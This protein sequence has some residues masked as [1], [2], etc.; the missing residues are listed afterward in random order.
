M[1]T[2][3]QIDRYSRQ[4]ILPEVGGRGQQR[5]SQS[6]LALA[7]DPAALEAILPYLA[8]AGVGCIHLPLVGQPLARM[9]A[10]I[11]K[12]NPEVRLEPWQDSSPP[13]D[14]T[15]FVLSRESE[16]PSL[17]ALDHSGVRP[18]MLIR[19]IAPRAI[20]TLASR[21][22]CLAC[23]DPALLAPACQ[24]PGSIELPA[25]AIAIAGGG[26]ILLQLL[27]LAAPA[28]RLLRCS[29]YELNPCTLAAGTCCQRCA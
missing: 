26:E 27:A 29:G 15:A 3:A 16:L 10:A 17:A 1:L 13:A 7:G 18:L 23:A 9:C 25:E 21:P 19:L 12:R 28:A 14:L 6:R 11:A 8:G 4:I 2:D 24:E 5:L 22:P 20:V